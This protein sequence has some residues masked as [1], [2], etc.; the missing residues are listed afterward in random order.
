[1]VYIIHDVGTVCFRHLGQQRQY[2]PLK[3]G[4]HEWFG[5]PNC[6]FGPYDN[7][8]TPNIPVYKDAEMAGR[9]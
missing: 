6:H 8:V 1:M 7:K 3:H 9:Y 5:S 2:H 4:F